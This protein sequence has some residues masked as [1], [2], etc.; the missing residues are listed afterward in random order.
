MTASGS[1]VLSIGVMSQVQHKCSGGIGVDSIECLGVQSI[2]SDEMS[3]LNSPSMEMAAGGTVD[4]HT[5]PQS[6]VT[7][8][9]IFNLNAR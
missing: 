3:H 7:S 2:P 1:E 9:G 5:L 6:R 4:Q 8:S